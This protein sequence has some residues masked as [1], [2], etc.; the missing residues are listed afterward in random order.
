MANSTAAKVLTLDEAAVKVGERVMSRDITSGNGVH[1][2]IVNLL[3]ENRLM[4]GP[5][6][7]RHAA[8]TYLDNTYSPRELSQVETDAMAHVMRAD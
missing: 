4:Q 7:L 2:L 5:L 6:A 1:L 8:R 3:E